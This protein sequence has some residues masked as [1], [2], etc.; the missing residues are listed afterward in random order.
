[1]TRGALIFAFDNEVTDYVAMAQWSAKN[2]RR[3]LDIPVAVV[4]DDPMAQGFDQVIYLCPEGN[5]SRH[6]ADYDA[7]VTWH[8]ESRAN[9]Y[10]LSP[11]DHTLLLDA[12][13]IVASSQL[14]S[15]FEYDQDFLA[16]RWA[17]DI[18]GLNDF[19][20]LNYFGRFRMPQWWATVIAFRKSDH[21]QF[22]FETME[23]IRDNWRHYRDLY[24]ISSPTYRN[25]YAMSIALNTVNGHVMNHPGIPW[26][27]SSLTPEHELTC[28]GQDVY[29]INYMDSENRARCISVAHR[30]FHAMGKKHLE[31][32]VASSG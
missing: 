21:A 7:T 26:P 17:T 27:L 23:M 1:M 5:N 16:H 32:I 8:N 22:I 19:S 12:D 11:W 20:G 15:L 13:Y 18:S 10:D 6:F 3:H 4:T 31:A 2:I 14:K 30:D 28:A 25:D 29:H 24:N 9:A